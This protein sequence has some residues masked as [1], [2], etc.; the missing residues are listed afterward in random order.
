MN[1]LYFLIIFLATIFLGAC[2]NNDSAAYDNSLPA[3][4]TKIVTPLT[5]ADT[6]LSDTATARPAVLSM[7]ANIQ[8]A[9]VIAATPTV[10]S[11][12][13]AGLNPAHGQP[14]H[15]CDI[16]VGASLSTPVSSPQVQSVN[17]NSSPTAM[18]VTTAPGVLGNSTAKLN[19]PHGQPGHDCAVEVG[20]PLKN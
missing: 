20:K 18:P 9:P 17:T 16:A 15:R 10:N 19:P 5:I 11:S 6:L 3:V 2:A 13:K 12:T 4:G 8:S 7:P 1:K 14:G